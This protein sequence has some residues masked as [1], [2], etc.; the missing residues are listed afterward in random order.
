MTSL[1]NLPI[2]WIN[3][4]NRNDRRIQLFEQFKKKHITQHTRITP[5]KAN[6]NSI[7][8]CLSHLEALLTAYFDGH[9]YVVVIEDDYEFPKKEIILDFLS[10]PKDWNCIQ[11][12]YICPVL[13]ETMIENQ[14]KNS[15]VE[16]Y[17]MGACCY[18]INRKGIEKFLN[19]MGYF[20]NKEYILTAKFQS[21]AR[22]E[23][24]VFRYINTYFLLY[25]I[26]NTIENFNSDIIEEE[27]YKNDINHK[28]M[29]L[30][31]ILQNKYQSISY[32]DLSYLK[33]PYETHWFDSKETC[34]SMISSLL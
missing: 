31:S 19:M 32:Q 25:P 34:K 33:L 13:L 27:Y 9:E 14:Y 24:F 7:S 29:N 4:I 30:I 17:M 28:N 12:C 26:G 23:E 20:E 15:I 8:C 5:K 18:L 11:L 16:G 21:N 10:F 1:F 2:Y 22:S 6:K 3:L